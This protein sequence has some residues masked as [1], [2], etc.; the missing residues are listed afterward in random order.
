MESPESP[1]RNS[2]RDP[3][4]EF[5][6]KAQAAGF[7]SNDLATSLYYFHKDEVDA[8]AAPL[9]QQ[10]NPKPDARPAFQPKQPASQTP[11]PA[12]SPPPVSRPKPAASRWAPRPS[13][14]APALRPEPAGT[15]T[16]GAQSAAAFTS[17]PPV[18]R[19]R[20][21]LWARLARAKSKKMWG[22][23]TADFAANALTYLG[24]LLAIIV[25]YVFFAFGYFGEAIDDQHKHFRPLVEIGVVAFFLGLAWVL[26]HRSGIPQTSTAVEVIG[27]VLI[28]IM[29]SASFRDGCTPAYR[30]WCMP[31]DVDGPARWAA[32]GGA[33]L[34]AAG[35]YYIYARRRSI[36]SYLIAPML[37]ISLGAFA[38]YL[39]DGIPLLRNGDTLRLTEF[40]RDGISAPQLIAVLAAIGL[41][42]AAAHRWRDSRLG[43][44]MAVPTVRAG[45]FFTPFVLILSLVFSY[46]DALSRG[47]VAPDLADLAW[48]NVVA[49]AF[50]AAVFAAA[51]GAG[52]AW[53]GLGTRVRRDT[54]LV[55]QVAAYVSLAAS[56]LLTA[57]FG[58]SPAW[59]GAGLIGYAV[60]IAVF[61]RF[62]AGSRIATVWIVRTALLVAGALSLL[63][64]GATLAAWGTL[65]VLAVL[66][67]TVP[68]TAGHV[69]RFVPVGGDAGERRFA[70]WA[71][72]LVTIGAG[73]TRMN[74]PEATPLVLLATGVVFAA[75]RL[76]PFTEL[77]SFATLPAAA[78]GLASLGVEVW[79]QA[80][81]VGFE[82]YIFSGFLLA[83]AGLAVLA[84]IPGPARGASVVGLTG[85]AA[86]V[87]LRE[88]FGPGLWEITWVDTSILAALGIALVA[89]S[90]A[91][92][93]DMVFYAIIGHGLVVAAAARSL[94]FEETAILGLGVLAMA[95][96]A[97]AINIE[98][99]RDGLFPR[100]GGKAGA[101]L[102]M[103]TLVAATTLV[104]LTLLIG[105]QVPIIA[106]ERARFGPVL[107]ALSWF[108]LTG[109]M[110]HIARAR[111]IAVPFAYGAAAAG[112]AVSAPSITAL[113]ATTISATAVT[114]ALAVR[115][116][117]P[118]ATIPTW[119]LAVAAGLLG[120]YRSGVGAADLFLVLHMAAALLVVAAAV[121]NLTRRT[122]RGGLASPWLVAP[123]YVGMMLLPAALALA[124]AD[125][126][127]IAWIAGSTALSIALLGVSTRAG[128]VSIPVATAISIGYA[129]VLFDND[130][131]HPFD[132][133][134][135]WMPL[136]AVFLA[137]AAVLPGNRRWRFLTD[138]APGLVVSALTIAAMSASY[139]HA[140]GVLDLALLAA[141]VLLAIVY[142]IRAE[143]PWLLAAGMS[144]ITAGL[145][146]GDYWA[147]A[148]TLAA[149]LVCGFWADRKRNEAA[150]IP[151]L[152]A[153][154]GG[155]AITFTLTGTWLEW[156]AAELT[157][158][159]GIGAVCI[160]PIAVTSTLATAWPPRI[161]M[162]TIPLHVIGH[163]LIVTSYMAG[164]AA[165]DGAT[166]FGLATLL[167]VLVAGE[168]GII[169]T[170]DR[171]RGLVAASAGLLGSAYVT[172]AYWRD[173]SV[174]E[175]LTYTA[176]TGAG[177][178]LLAIAGYLAARLPARVRLWTWPI[179]TLGQA[180]GVA[181]VSVAAD[182]LDPSPAAGIAAAV[183]AYDAV[184]AGLPGTMRR[185]RRL[186][187]VSSVLAAGAYSL[188]PQWLV[189]TRM[190]FIVATSAAAAVLG[191]AATLVTRLRRG[192]LWEAP[193]HG[194]TIAAVCALVIKTMAVVPQAGELWALTGMAFGFASYVAS[195]ASAAP[196]EWG[197]RT[198]AVSLYIGSAGLAIGAEVVRDGAV[199]LALLSIA[200][201]GLMLA[202]AAGLLAGSDRPWRT[203]LALLALGLVTLPPIV[204]PAVFDPLGVEM[205]TVLIIT[206][207]ALAAYGLLAHDLAVIE[208][209]MVVWL[210]ALMILV[211]QQM[212]LTLHASVIIVSVTLLATVELERHRRHLADQPVPHGLHH[213]EWLLMLAPLVLA[214]PEMFD[215]LWYGLALFAEGALL[216]GW[217]ALS[218][219]RRRALLG[220]GAMVAA[221]L[222]SVIIPALHGISAGL[223]GGT[224]LV[225]GAIAATLFIT[226]GSAIE[227]RRHTIGRRL[228]HIAEILEHWE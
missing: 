125:G 134:L 83:L 38:L 174:A 77:R 93:K 58:V 214:V 139:S 153:T 191:A 146:A 226:A 151:L 13:A 164:V 46:N 18:R 44:V 8:A 26:R 132:Q 43:K 17:Q 130:W 16:P 42:I 141:A 177:L 180:A 184:L 192:L 142:W 203:E 199:F 223:T 120:A 86:T 209:A 25:V 154:T 179:L 188:V 119:L 35:I 85:A 82:P 137:A 127:W 189:W 61:D 96:V 95:H 133:P 111:R 169:G 100:L 212:E 3:V 110:Q 28:P 167:L 64:P 129:A 115:L 79:R 140:A 218:E 186:V 123:V 72:V 67:V 172:F 194:L 65:S 10:P 29:L 117:R 207:G 221:I 219:V 176:I 201:I 14:P 160:I 101:L 114:A 106:D 52:F 216:A 116:G 84:D 161:A 165:G 222:L 150:A 138:P 6:R 200:G 62:F 22:T 206:G 211:N 48:P 178:T 202:S 71:P 217:G 187:A 126:G 15:P 109:A 11:S 124:I 183:L 204:V 162:W 75:T 92:A 210:G 152:A 113:L 63:E 98:L 45:V 112:I 149:S 190:E 36:Y 51:A 159:A 156:T 193:L 78:A 182:S 80:D 37:W 228:A 131:A 32:Y 213:L 4:I 157:A 170:V 163:G 215:S 158:I 81:G 105:R 57:G 53:A 7:L 49:T 34:I 33:G 196:G 12:P 24:V 59:L 39:E 224:W 41:T 23:F 5:L 66:R 103:P 40:T 107:A 87:A 122:E 30:P 31:P 128:G 94:W 1:Q 97:E 74:W 91:G 55:L 136:A 197:L 227:R 27:I 147:P 104:P 171:E 118:Q 108:Y 205:G 47:V 185:D 135:V 225:I 173:W 20:A 148:A 181:V 88:Y 220:V 99:G 198:M 143:E 9:Q 121:L 2:G 89:A 208:G 168:T 68:A 54:A 145:V 21:E 155:V 73:A 144:L 60:V 90:L 166:P 102:A 50:A 69:D 195:N 76:L 56:W 175:V 19:S 70:L